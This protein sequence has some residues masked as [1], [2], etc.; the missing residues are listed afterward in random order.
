MPKFRTKMQNSKMFG[1]AAKLS[2]PH[3]DLRDLAFQ[4]SGERTEHTSELTVKECDELLKWLESKLPENNQPSQRTVN[5][6][7][8]QLGFRAGLREFEQTSRDL[9]FDV[10]T[11]RS[12]NVHI[13]DAEVIE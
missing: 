11:C 5:Y 13:L 3:E 9:T 2:L 1:L 4:F 7:K 12:E 6:H 8:Q 10:C